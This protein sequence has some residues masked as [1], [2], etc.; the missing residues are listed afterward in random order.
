MKEKATLDATCSAIDAAT[1]SA[2]HGNEGA[3]SI[4]DDYAATSASSRSKRD[5]S[6]VVGPTMP[7][8]E[9][10]VLMREAFDEERVAERAYQRKRARQEDKERVE[11][12]VGP[13]EQGREGALEKKRARRE[14]DRS[15]RDA[16]DDAFG[17]FDESTLMG[18]GDSFQARYDHD[19]GQHYQHVLIRRCLGLLSVTPRGDV[20]KRNGSQQLRI[21][22]TL[23]ATDRR[24]YERKIMPL[25][26]CS[27]SWLKR[28]S[29]HNRH[30]VTM[31][32]RAHNAVRSSSP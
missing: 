14:A 21:N 22:M 20:T 16:K 31:I 19:S 12:M 23:S 9:D 28:N 6:R 3:D 24:L 25:W 4:R 8:A 11:D 5:P 1:R 18:G 30:L 7:T 27:S 32:C 13:K 17:D 2:A 29:A 26:R 10:R 15:S